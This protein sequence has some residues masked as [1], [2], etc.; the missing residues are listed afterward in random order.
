MNLGVRQVVVARFDL[1]LNLLPFRYSCRHW[2]QTTS[3]KRDIH[4]QLNKCDSSIDYRLMAVASLLSVF[5]TS[6][7]YGL[8]Q[9]KPF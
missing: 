2:L 9:T 1:H 3:H 4:P 6:S 5:S 8:T 7:G